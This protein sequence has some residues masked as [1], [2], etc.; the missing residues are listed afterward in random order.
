MK[1]EH[2]IKKNFIY[3]VSYQ[4]LTIILP[5]ITAPYVTRVLGAK[6]LGVYSKTQA[7]AHYFLLFAML[8]VN[9]YG[10]RAIARVRDNREKASKTFWE[11]YT[12]QFVTAVIATAL[13][14]FYCIQFTSEN[15]LIYMMQSFY[16]MSGLLDVNW[17]CF[18]MEKFK[19]TTIRSM[20]VRILT[21][22]AVFTLV[23]SKDDLWLY[24][25]IISFGHIVSSLVVWPF[26]KKHIDFIKP[27]WDGIKRHIKPNLVLFWPVIA[28][29]LYNI[30]DKIMLGWFSEDEEVAFYTYAERIVTIPTTLILALDNVI[31]PRMSN[32]YA[33]EG[34]NEKIKYLMDNVMMFAMFMAAA[35]GF[36]LAGIADVFAPWFYG[37]AFARCGFFIILLSPV[38]IVKAWA[39][40]LRTQ[41][42]IPTG[43][44]IIYVI[45]LTTGA[46]VNLFLNALLIPRINGIG[47]IIGTLAAE[48]AVCFIQ[49]FLCRKDID[50]KNYLINGLWFCV[51]GAIMF[52]LIEVLS[53][54]SNHAVVTMAVQIVSGAIIY[55][56]LGSFYM[57]KIRKN[58]VLVNE[59]LKMLRIKYRFN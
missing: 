3:S 8:G 36:G 10:N 25:F 53:H 31:M 34:K 44:D 16:V 56:G 40:A 23:N 20:V 17:C 7:W 11:I 2:N 59:G 9:N 4:I 22:L 28:V 48:F 54:V 58:P 33:S 52:F 24:T 18:G 19:L 42:I 51:I 35:M 1:S 43:R 12:F 46:I 15:R 29:S 13:Y 27:T 38:I 5:L 47:A 55:I 57:I 39:G 45:S 49:F 30:M 41:F 37:S 26:I 14:W 6:G 50:I 32:L 21:A